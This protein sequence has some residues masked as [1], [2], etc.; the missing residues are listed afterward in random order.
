MNL[1]KSGGNVFLLQSD[2]EKR[3]GDDTIGDEFESISTAIKSLIDDLSSNKVGNLKSS[4]NRPGE[5]I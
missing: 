4:I 5:Y 1:Y 2:L 3:F